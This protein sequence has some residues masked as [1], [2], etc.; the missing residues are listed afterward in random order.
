[1][2]HTL[3]K[4]HPNEFELKFFRNAPNKVIITIK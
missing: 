1:M 3:K 2:L 4:K